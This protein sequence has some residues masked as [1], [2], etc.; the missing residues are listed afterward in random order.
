MSAIAADVR[1]CFR[2]G[3][4]VD[5]VDI[6][7]ARPADPLPAGSPKR[8]CRIDLILDMDQH[9][10]NHGATG[11][12]VDLVRVEARIAIGVRIKSVDPH[13]PPARTL[14]EDTMPYP[15]LDPR[16]CRKS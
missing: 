11:S 4:G 7:R 2:T 14:T 5:S 1:A 13:A 8:E 12:H 9:I 16:T 3:Q 10:K 15:R 6:H